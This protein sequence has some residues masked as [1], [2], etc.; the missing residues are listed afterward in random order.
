MRGALK[1]TVS[2]QS[3]TVVLTALPMGVGTDLL[4]TWMAVSVCKIST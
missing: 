2:L 1:S 4:C 3:K